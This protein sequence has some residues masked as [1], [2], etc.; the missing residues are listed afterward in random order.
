MVLHQF[1]ISLWLSTSVIYPDLGISV[2]FTVAHTKKYHISKAWFI[3]LLIAG[4]GSV[5]ACAAPTTPAPTSTPSPVPS[6]KTPTPT[7]VWFPATATYTPFPITTL[8]PT[9]DQRPGIGAIALS[10]DFS[11]PGAWL[12]SRTE[13]GSVAVV[14]NELTI[15]IPENNQRIY[16]FSVRSEPVLTNFYLELTASPSLCCGK[17]EY[18]L[19]L[20]VSPGLDYYRF[21]LA[22]DGNLRLDRVVNGQASSPQP[23][24]LS[25]AVPPGAP[26]IVRLGVWANQDEMRFFVNDYYQFT[27]RDPLLTS[28]SVGVFARAASDRA[29]TVNFSSLAIY[30]ITALPPAQ[31]SITPS[32]NPTE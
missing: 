14:N 31:P 18:G 28:G 3:L 2:S 26:S 1:Y 5:S 20:R 10:D 22:C 11:D 29:V 6:T 23:W 25:G 27:V 12:Q 16:L 32:V 4:L 15:A 8:Q 19:L 24:L 30:D 9:P 7:I 21:S 17:D 13:E